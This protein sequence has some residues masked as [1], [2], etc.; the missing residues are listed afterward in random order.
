MGREKFDACSRCP[1]AERRGKPVLLYARTHTSQDVGL[2]PG[3]P[4][5]SDGL[6]VVVQA[7]ATANLAMYD[8]ALWAKYRWRELF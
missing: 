7:Y 6:A 2:R 4:I 5:L 1:E 8:D 3:V